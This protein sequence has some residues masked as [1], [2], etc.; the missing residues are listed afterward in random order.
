MEVARDLSEVLARCSG[1]TIIAT[2]R[3]V[4]GLQAE[5]E[6]PVLPLP[7]PAAAVPPAELASSPAVS[8][9]VERARAVRPGFA[10]TE[11]NAAAVA[12][13]C[14][15]LEGL[16]LAIEL[17]AARTRLLDPEALVDRLSRSLDALGTGT[18]DLPAR[19]QTLRAT[20]EWSVDLLEE[21]ERSLLQVL[22]VFVDGW[23]TEAAA[24]VADV[25]ED[26]ALELSEALVRHSLVYLDSTARGPRLRMLETIR[27]FVGEQ[28]AAR[29][30][31]GEIE[32]RHADYYRSLADLGARP[33]RGAGWSEWADRLRAEQGN[34]ATAVR[35]YLSYDRAPLPHLFRQLLPL[36]A[37]ESDVL[38][39]ARSW[40]DQLLPAADSLEPEAR[41]ELLSTAAVTAREVGDD[42]AALAARQ[43]LA[44]LLETI[45]DPYLKAVSELTIAW[46]SAILGD[47]DGALRD[48]AA[49][50][51]Q[52][53]SQDE[54][55]WT[56]AALISVGS[57]EMATGRHDD[58]QRHLHEARELAERF[59][60]TRLVL[61]SLV[62]LGVLAV[63]SSRAEDA[64]A[65]LDEALDLSLVLHSTRN[66]TLIL[67]AFA[68]LCFE[69]GDPDRSALLMGAAEGLRRR[70]GLRIWP[71]A[72]RGPAEL[73]AKVRE[74]LGA[75]RFD[76][77]SA[78]GARLSQREA[79]AAVR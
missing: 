1:V 10:L 61:G 49:S 8:L 7:I 4:L 21:A 38:R 59:G 79:A 58:A 28:L 14:R 54:P 13:I 24:S 19:Q 72:R 5:R 15:R 74:S 32:R 66:V 34:L 43:R 36:W 41:A 56:T 31:V 55:L 63:M 68:Q 25:D 39:E 27:A 26:K 17:A 20:V 62:Q 44:P 37:V 11:S 22:A 75:D 35:W 2:S 46:T 48:A 16:P 33:L 57:V 67:G 64:H 76:R 3:T 12:E 73:V 47:P 23:T 65:L 70:A 29:P 52:L 51:A 69:E 45:R 42:S 40:V 78:E 50:L 77:R 53:R 71:T 6:F 60:N 18:V 30:D 9:F